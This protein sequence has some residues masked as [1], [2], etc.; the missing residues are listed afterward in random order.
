[1]RL[2][3]DTVAVGRHE[4]E[5]LPCSDQKNRIGIVQQYTGSVTGSIEAGHVYMLACTL[6]CT[7]S[8]SPPPDQRKQRIN[9]IPLASWV[10]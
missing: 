5:D 6:L 1:M 9:S 3:I 4:M 8:P 10:C 7:E 2:C